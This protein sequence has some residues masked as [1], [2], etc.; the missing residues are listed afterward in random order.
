MKYRLL[1]E[2][3]LH[4]LEESD[5]WRKHGWK[6]GP[7]SPAAKV[8][9]ALHRCYRELDDLC[10]EVKDPLFLSYVKDRI[11]ERMIED[12]DAGSHGAPRNGRLIDSPHS[13]GPEEYESEPAYIYGHG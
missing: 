9:I 7:N 3:A 8:D 12:W 1:K 4:E 5:D 10:R 11:K 13:L 6:F 2:A